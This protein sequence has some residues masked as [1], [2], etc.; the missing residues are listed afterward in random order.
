MFTTY[1]PVKLSALP[2]G[3][4]FTR[5]E[6]A[7]RV[8]QLAGYDKV[9]NVFLCDDTMDGSEVWLAGD[10]IVFNGFDY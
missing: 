7:C 3:E 10:A 6:G 4:Y 5:K 2:M 1:N 9:K 8:Y